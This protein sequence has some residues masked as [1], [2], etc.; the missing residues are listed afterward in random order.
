LFTAAPSGQRSGCICA[1]AHGGSGEDTTRQGLRINVIF[2][3]HVYIFQI[4]NHLQ[5]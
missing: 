5:A 1:S 3:V 2:I 4:L